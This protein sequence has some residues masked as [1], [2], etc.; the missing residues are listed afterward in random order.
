MTLH[1]TKRSRFPIFVGFAHKI[2]SV[3][4]FAQL[5]DLCNKMLHDADRGVNPYLTL[6]NEYRAL[7]LDFYPGG[8]PWEYGMSGPS[9]VDNFKSA[10]RKVQKL[11][12]DETAKEE[13]SENAKP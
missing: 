4:E 11:I 1:K 13:L 5:N 9:R 3:A 8:P 6:S 12:K 2:P 10:I 7:L